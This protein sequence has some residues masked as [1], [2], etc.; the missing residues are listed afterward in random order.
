[1]RA[2]VLAAGGAAI[3]TILGASLATAGSKK[4]PQ[5]WKEQ[6]SVAGRPSVRVRTGDARVIVHTR[7]GSGVAVEVREKGEQKGLF[8]GD[9]DPQVQF[10]RDGSQIDIEA[11][12]QGITGGIVWSDYRLEVDL[13]VP[14]E[15]NLDIKTRDG[16]VTLGPLSGKIQV[17]TNDGDIA[18]LGLRGDLTLLS[19]DGDIDAGDLDGRLRLRTRD[20]DGEIAGRF[21]ALAARASDGDIELTVTRGSALAEPWT[22]ES[23]D[24]RIGLRIP[25]DLKAYVDA[26]SRDGSLEFDLPVAVRG[27][28]RRNALEGELNGGSQVLTLRSSDGSIHVTALR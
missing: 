5:V 18:A 13:W 23:S 12:M 22:I 11:R 8:V 19:D 14:R 27:K 15:T 16:D 10:Q 7:E 26:R 24:G 21:D 9:R 6:W 20:G 17:E 25:P 28:V 2:R 1:M 3:L 4:Q